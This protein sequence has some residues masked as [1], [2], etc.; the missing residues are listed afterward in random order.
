M[1]RVTASIPAVTDIPR[2]HVLDG[3]Y[4]NVLT[5]QECGS[6][7]APVFEGIQHHYPSSGLSPYLLHFLRV[8]QLTQVVHYMFQVTH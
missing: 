6:I 8:A 7:V 1:A 2:H 5:L 3:I 4:A